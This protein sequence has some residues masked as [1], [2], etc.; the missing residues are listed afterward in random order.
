MEY[1]PAYCDMIADRIKND[2]QSMME[3]QTGPIQMDLHPSEGY[4][5]STKKMLTITDH[6]GKMYKV[7]VEEA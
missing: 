7:T 1:T 6:N 2:C 3:W 5:V 4:M